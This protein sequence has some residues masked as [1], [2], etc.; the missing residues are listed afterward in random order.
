MPNKQASPEKLAEIVVQGMLEK[1]AHHITTI[2]LRKLGAS[3]T[4]IMVICHGDSDRQVDAIAHSV[5]DEVKKQTGENPFSREGFRE[6]NWI[7]VDYINVVAH[8]FKKDMREFY[9]IEDLWGD[10]VVTEITTD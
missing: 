3:V 1:K 2:D 10:G 9:G 7:L 5:I 4:D 6:G 8:V